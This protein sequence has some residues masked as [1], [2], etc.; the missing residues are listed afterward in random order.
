MGSVS[1]FTYFTYESVLTY[2]YSGSFSAIDRRR[3]SWNQ[4]NIFKA[5]IG[6]WSISKT[7]EDVNEI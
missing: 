3:G 4:G 5:L 6:S 7:S 2:I 1:C